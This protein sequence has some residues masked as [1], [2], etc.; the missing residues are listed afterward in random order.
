MNHALHAAHRLDDDLP[1]IQSTNWT[2]IAAGYFTD[3]DSGD[4]YWT[5]DYNQQ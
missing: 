5:V 3:P 1:S 2:H 4:N